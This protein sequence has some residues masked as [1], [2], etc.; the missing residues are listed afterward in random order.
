MLSLARSALGRLMECQSLLPTMLVPPNL[1][2]ARH[3]PLNP[4]PHVWE[5]LSSKIR[6]VAA[7][8]F[9]IRSGIHGEGARQH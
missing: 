2:F 5:L 8:T 4:G 6:L 7:D 1:L 9:D 3:Q